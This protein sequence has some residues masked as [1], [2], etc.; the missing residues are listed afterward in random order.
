MDIEAKVKLFLF[1]L[2]DNVDAGKI[3]PTH[4]K[5]EKIDKLLREFGWRRLQMFEYLVKNL[6]YTDYL[7]GPMDDHD[8]S[9]GAL[10][11]FG[12]TILDKDVYIKIKQ[13]DDGSKCLSFHEKEQEF[14]F[15]FKGG[16]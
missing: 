6:E 7:S 5:D 1:Q 4:R 9:P 2:E 11:T 15:P 10:W 16:S 3:I 12:K 8:N 14:D 13:Q